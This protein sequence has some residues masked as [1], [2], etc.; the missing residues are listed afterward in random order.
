M[1]RSLQPQGGVF[2]QAEAAKGGKVGI[3]NS[4]NTARM[5][6]R[7]VSV[8]LCDQALQPVCIV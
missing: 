8:T 3:P 2:P 1:Q 5:R 6:I 7:S 4:I